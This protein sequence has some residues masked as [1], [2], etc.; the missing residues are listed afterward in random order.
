MYFKVDDRFYS[1]PKV[2]RLGR[3]RLAAVGL[4]TLAGSWVCQFETDGTIPRTVVRQFDA[5]LRTAQRLVDAG[6]WTEVDQNGASSY[7]FVDWDQWQP[8]HDRMEEIRRSRREAGRR[9]GSASGESRR[10]KAEAN[11][12]RL[13][14]ADRTQ[15]RPDQSIPPSGGDARART[16]CP[17]HADL[18]DDDPGPPCRGC[19]AAREEAEWIARLDAADAAAR[20][21]EERI[22]AQ[23]AARDAPRPE[24][25]NGSAVVRAVLAERKTR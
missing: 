15:T 7:R 20:E 14:E 18:P 24:V 8:T 17:R 6:L 9:G 12:S 25:R 4:W 23:L 11:A 22:R 16:R 21:R 5:K 2:H 13:L 10:S 1:H 19:M 3:M